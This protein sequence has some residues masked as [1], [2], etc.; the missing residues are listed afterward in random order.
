[1]IASELANTPVTKLLLDR[2]DA[3][4][5]AKEHHSI[6]VLKVAI[7][8]GDETHAVEVALHPTIQAWIKTHE[9]TQYVGAGGGWHIFSTTGAA[10]DAG[11]LGLVQVLNQLHQRSVSRVV[12]FK[13]Y[14]LYRDAPEVLTTV[15]RV[16]RRVGVHFAH[17]W[18]W[19][20]VREICLVRYGCSREARDG[21]ECLLV[22][23]PDGVFH[24]IVAFVV[25]PAFQLPPADENLLEKIWCDLMNLYE[26][27][28]K[29]Y[30]AL[31]AAGRL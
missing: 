31:H 4:Q 18:R 26:D 10:V 2:L 28:L 6:K 1:V 8:T 23:L 13:I 14:R 24:R 16:L 15:P 20:Q 12:W 19:K 11:M 5:S 29:L 27:L 3:W 25:P 17:T 7:E 21:E 9:R 22:S 30:G